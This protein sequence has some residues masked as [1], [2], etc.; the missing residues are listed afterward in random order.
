M[1]LRNVLIALL[2]LL[3]LSFYAGYRA[4]HSPNGGTAGPDGRRILYYVDPMNPSFRSSEPGVAPCGMPLEPVYADGAPAGAGA[5]APGVVAVRADRQQL[6]GVTLETVG[7][8]TLRH[9]VRL[10]GRVAVDEAR[11]HRLNAVTPGWIREMGPATTGS[12]VKKGEVLAAYYAPEL[13]APLQNFIYTVETY[14]KVKR[15]GSNPYDNLQGGGQLAAYE[16]NLATGQRTLQNLGMPAE[17]IDSVR[18]SGEFAWLVE[19]RSPTTGFV[20]T[21]NVSNGQRFE[22]STELYTIADLGR[23]WILADAFEGDTRLFEPG[24][25]ATVSHPSLGKT[26]AARVSPVLPQFD[27]ATR[28]LKVRLEADNPGFVLRPDMFVDV[29]MTVE[30]GPAL[31]VPKEAVLD[32]GTRRV[33]YVARG[34]GAFEPRRV[35]VGFREADR[36]EIVSGL[37]EGERVVTSGN[38]LLDSESR[39]RAAGAEE[40]PEGEAH[41]HGEAGAVAAASRTDG[42]GREGPDLRHDRGHRRGEGRRP[43]EHARGSHLLLLRAG[44]QGDLRQGPCGPREATVVIARVVDFSVR[45]PLVVFAA[46]AVAA[47]AGIVVHPADAARRHPRPLRHP[48]HR[49]LPLGPLPRR[50]RGP[51][52]LPDRDR[53]ARGPRGARGAGLLRLRLLVRLRRLRGRDRPLLGP[54]AHARVPLDRPALAPRGRQDRA[55]ARR[56]GPRLGVPVRARGRVGRAQ[57]RRPALA[58]RTGTSATT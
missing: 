55:R 48:G 19:I 35:E 25:R 52:H 24:A 53:H 38:F 36:V 45:N 5:M 11:L 39:M 29:E 20:L 41:A 31:T 10:L 54:L 27:P 46:V 12:L 49:L 7:R 9:T 8:R 57:P 47:F 3:P 13:T 2:V 30:L 1:R 23:V 6:I 44:L 58:A 40:T 43:D 32:S 42:R 33:V 26:L 34:E 18:A 37:G 16:R 4:K 21:R 14:E 15:T 22:P 50:R 56:A 28:T 17:Q 51:G